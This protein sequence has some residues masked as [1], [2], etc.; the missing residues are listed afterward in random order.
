MGLGT[1]SFEDAM[2]AAKPQKWNT[3]FIEDWKTAA[4][5]LS[6]ILDAEGNFKS[7]DEASGRIRE[8]ANDIWADEVKPIIKNHNAEV[9][10]TD[11]V[12]DALKKEADILSQNDP[13]AGKVL[14]T[15]AEDFNPSKLK[16]VEQLESRLEFY[17]KKLRAS[18]FYS[19]PSEE[20]NALLGT[21]PQITAWKTGADAIRENLYAH[22]SNTPDGV[23]IEKLKNEYGAMSNVA[24]SVKGQVNVAGR[25]VPISLKQAIGL[26][27]GIAHGGPTGVAAAALPIIDKLYNDPTALLNRAISKSAGPGIV[28]QV[29][30]A[31]G[32]VAKTAIK[33]GAAQVGGPKQ[34]EEQ[35]NP[36]GTPI[37]EA[38][39]EQPWVRMAMSNGQHVEIHP[40]D[41][42]EA[43]NRGLK[44]VA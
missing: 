6:K 23:N 18:G 29:A 34:P 33:T 32:K 8:A 17:N 16:T 12:Y 7:M 31:A 21:D 11:P 26:A 22:L 2:R 36:D 1:D 24:K 41:V 3:K 9:V 25:Q 38:G 30:T 10:N 19:K 39:Q 14:D 37:A 42:E 35:T 20:Q 43:K 44:E 28:R 15:M 13:S 4:P 27:A 5:R 40:E